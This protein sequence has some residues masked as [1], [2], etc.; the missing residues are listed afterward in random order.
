[1][2]P[3]GYINRLAATDVRSKKQDEN[4]TEVLSLLASAYRIDV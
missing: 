2:A 1:V 3:N 4:L